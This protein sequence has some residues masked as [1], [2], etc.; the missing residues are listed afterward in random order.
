[1][2]HKQN[3]SCDNCEHT[4]QQMFNS[5]FIPDDERKIIISTEQQYNLIKDVL[6]L[7][8]EVSSLSLQSLIMLAKD[9]RE[10]DND[11]CHLFFDV[12]SK[13]ES[14]PIRGDELIRIHYAPNGKEKP[15]GGRQNS[16]LQTGMAVIRSGKRIAIDKDGGFAEDFND[17]EKIILEA[18]NGM[19]DRLTGDFLDYVPED[20]LYFDIPI[21]DD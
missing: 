4:R 21:A 6:S 14:L 17:L 5:L 2:K 7:P 18:Y 15:I 9:V 1:M 3:C 11:L 13:C 19:I 12:V 8:P 20:V 10:L 16:I